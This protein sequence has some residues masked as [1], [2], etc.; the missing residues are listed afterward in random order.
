[1]RFSDI[2]VEFDETSQVVLDIVTI[3]AGED[4]HS[5]PLDAIQ[6]ELGA[7]GI[8]IDDNALFDLL[9]TLAIVDNIKDD[10]V[11]FNTDSAAHAAGQSGE[12]DAEVDSE[13]VVKSM[14]KKQVKK[15]LD[16]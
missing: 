6:Q 12:V 9:Q 1:M 2:L 15:G 11:Y 16:K 14:A 4:T 10:I 5:L 8:D 3:M 7:Q 13:K